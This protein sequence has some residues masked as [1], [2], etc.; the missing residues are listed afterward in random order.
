[1]RRLLVAGV[2]A[3]LVAAFGLLL[4]ARQPFSLVAPS[5]DLR[6]YAALPT[7]LAAPAFYAEPIVAGNVVDQELRLSAQDVAIRLWLGPAR[8]RTS[9][10]VH[11]ELLAGPH[12]PSLRSGVVD[13]SGMPDPIVARIVPPL[14][15]SELGGDSRTLLR[16]APADE[17]SPIRVGMAHG[18][19]YRPGRTYIA[20]ELLPADQDVMFEVAGELSPGDVYSQVWTL[21]QSDTLPVRAAAAVTPAVLVSVLA[22][23]LVGRNRKTYSALVFAV[24]MLAALVIVIDRTPVSLFPGPDFNPTVILR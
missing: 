15:P 10:R 4:V 9:A 6:S 13:V 2:V 18:A 21:M 19:T 16:L 22:A 20:G 14:R 12:G 24:V 11:I 17:S 23:G 5:P 7:V 1:M 8:A 3:G